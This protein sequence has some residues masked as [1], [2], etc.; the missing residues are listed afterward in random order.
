LVQAT[1]FAYFSLPI[2][3]LKH[4]SMSPSLF[5]L[6]FCVF[7]GLS[8]EPGWQIWAPD[9]VHLVHDGYVVGEGDVHI[10]GSHHDHAGPTTAL[11]EDAETSIN[12]ATA[13]SKS[14]LPAMVASVLTAAR[15]KGLL[16]AASSTFLFGAVLLLTAATYRL[17]PG[18]TEEV[19][20]QTPSSAPLF[21]S[22]GYT[23]VA[24]VGTCLFLL[25]FGAGLLV[26]RS[27]SSASRGESSRSR[28]HES[29]ANPCVIGNL[30]DEL[31][32]IVDEHGD[33]LAGSNVCQG[34]PCITGDLQHFYMGTP[35]TSQFQMAAA[36]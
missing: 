21:M 33:K 18:S 10:N 23:F 35:N 22:S 8:V 14:K 1:G 31:A 4:S 13:A 36:A 12:P 2:C 32:A 7:A 30:C 34:T 9:R 15:G 27:V 5:L 28:T 20:S 29:V 6:W 11:K 25:G 19:A 26:G 24:F 17:G 16:Q 3:L